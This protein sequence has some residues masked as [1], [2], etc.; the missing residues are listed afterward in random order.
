MQKQFIQFKAH[1]VKNVE[2]I[3]I[4]IID[5]EGIEALTKDPDNPGGTRVHTNEGMYLAAEPI[6]YFQNLLK[7]L[8]WEQ[9]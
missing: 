3:D 9:K 4:A 1:S 2:E 6:E 7:P 8:G 5:V